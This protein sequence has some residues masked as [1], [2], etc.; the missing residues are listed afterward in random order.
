MNLTQIKG[1][2]WELHKKAKRVWIE[3]ECTRHT[4][5]HETLDGAVGTHVPGGKLGDKQAYFDYGDCML[6][7]YLDGWIVCTNYDGDELLKL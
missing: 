3:D 5:G 2:A 6:T 1:A 4:E 7:F